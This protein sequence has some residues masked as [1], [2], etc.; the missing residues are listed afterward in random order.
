VSALLVG[1]LLAAALL[2]AGGGRPRPPVRSAPAVPVGPD[3]A[4]VVA[5]DLVIELVAA[6]LDAG[7]PAGAAV[8][9]AA[10]ACGPP[11]GDE[12]APA[13]EALRLGLSPERAWALLPHGH[14]A[15]ARALLVSERTGAAV[16]T[17]LRRAA[18]D[19]RLA[20]AARV[21]VAARRLGVHQVLPLGLATLPAFVLLAVAPV[22][23]GLAAPLLDGGW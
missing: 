8:A 21:Q 20:R 9:A 4:L 16:A 2:V 6:A 15:L 11:V 3:A 10:R 22:V 19:A 7:L 23:L 12:L 1:A 17:V 5:A 18:A 13:L 14:A